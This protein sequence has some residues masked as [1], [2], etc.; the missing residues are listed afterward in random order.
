M[1]GNVSAVACWVYV[2]LVPAECAVAEENPGVPS[3][4]LLTWR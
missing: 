4:P 1:S 3:L 2:S